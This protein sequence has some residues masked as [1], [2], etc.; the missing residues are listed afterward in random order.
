MKLTTKHTINAK[1]EVFFEKVF[2]DREFND[3]LY[4][5]FLQMKGFSIERLDFEDSK[6]FK[7]TR[8]TPKQDAPGFVKK[9]INGELSYIEDGVLDRKSN[10]YTYSTVTSVAADRIKVEGD[11]IAKPLGDDKCERTVNI[12]VRVKV[13]LIGGKLER[14]VGE[15]LK[16]NFD[17]GAAYTNQW[18]ADQGIK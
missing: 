15:Q 14:F 8:V 4:L 1:P 13:P 11:V 17:K 12:T 9:V 7:R 3:K 2:L 6:V 16:S 10:V 18:I 5:E